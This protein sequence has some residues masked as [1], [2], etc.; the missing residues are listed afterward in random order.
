MG[1]LCQSDYLGECEAGQ[2]R[3]LNGSLFCEPL[4]G[5][6]QERCDLLDNDCDGRFD[7]EGETIGEACISEAFGLCQTGQWQ[8]GPQGE[9]LC[10]STQE[11]QVELCDLIDND[12]DGLTDENVFAENDLECTT[13]EQGLCAQGEKYCVAGQVQCRSTYQVQEERCDGL[14]NDCDGQVDESDPSLGLDCNIDAFGPCA[15]GYTVC[16]QGQLSCQPLS[17]P[18]DELYDQ[19]DNDCDGELDEDFP[20]LGAVVNWDSVFALGAVA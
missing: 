6:Q 19:I 2:L 8:C 12:C 17:Q 10:V 4:Q 14:D 18:N 1:E 20:A 9:W 13:N 3:C 16:E 11:P 7:E 5:P 15:F